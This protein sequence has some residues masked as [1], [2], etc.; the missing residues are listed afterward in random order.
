V[1]DDRHKAITTRPFPMPLPMPAVIS[2]DDGLY[3]D[4]L[5][6]ISKAEPGRSGSPVMEDR[7]LPSS[8]SS[9]TSVLVDTAGAEITE[10]V[11]GAE[12][13]RDIYLPKHTEWISHVAID[14]S[15]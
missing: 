4:R 10:P 8:T 1:Q 12:G 9:R 7:L 3:L 14:V 6:A 11:E 13:E 5:T 2:A 15:H